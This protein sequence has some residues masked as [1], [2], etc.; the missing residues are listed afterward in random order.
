MLFL[1]AIPMMAY[2]NFEKKYACGWFG[3]PKY[4]K[5]KLANRVS[6]IQYNANN[7]IEDRIS[8]KDLVN[9]DGFAALV[10]DGHG[11]WQIVFRSLCRRNL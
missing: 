8:Y 1:A 5:N 4:Y 3:G 6:T 7:P 2:S 11:G 9:I 10:L